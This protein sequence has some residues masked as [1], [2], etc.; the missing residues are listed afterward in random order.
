[1]GKEINVLVVDDSVF[2][3]Q[4]I[5]TII[6]SDP[7]LN[8]AATAKNGA[9]ALDILKKQDFDVITMD[10]NMPTMDGITALKHIMA[11][12]PTPVLMISALTQKGADETMQ[13]LELGAID[14]VS[15]PSG[16]ISFDIEEQRDEIVEKVRAAASS[17]LRRI[18]RP[19]VVK[20]LKRAEPD[21][22]EEAGPD[23]EISKTGDCVIAIGASTGGP[24]TLFEIIPQFPEDLDATVFVVQHMPVL[25]T[26]TF[27]ERLNLSSRIYVKEATDNE[28]VKKGTVYLAK[29]NAQMLI[30]Q[31]PG[32]SRRII[33]IDTETKRTYTPNVDPTF[34]SIAET[35]TNNLIGVIITGMGNDG[36]DGLLKIR[37]R[38][39]RTIAEDESTSVIYG[40][41]KAAAKNGA[42]EYVLPAGEIAEKVL[43]LVKE[44][45]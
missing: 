18:S 37:E 20:E 16:S 4:I 35:C 5:T 19:K 28:F 24:S 3:R 33:K 43:S 39:G 25:F 6:E 41:P 27:A 45:A 30:R 12:K 11:S 21:A 17:K 22:D 31:E 14:Y 42:A 8:V 29:G 36:A 23:T 26:K 10:I 34:N 9:V 2:M 7:D 40:M 15:K 1:M 38:G 13:S 32:T 44:E